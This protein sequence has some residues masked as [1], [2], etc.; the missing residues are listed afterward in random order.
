MSNTGEIDEPR[1][2]TKEKPDLRRACEIYVSGQREKDGL[3]RAGTTAQK[4]VY[5]CFFSYFQDIIWFEM[6]PGYKLSRG[7]K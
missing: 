6:E 2:R 1:R 4:L 5:E 7:L 3:S